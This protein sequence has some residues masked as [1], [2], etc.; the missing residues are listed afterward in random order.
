MADDREPTGE[1]LLYQTEDGRTR[2]ECRFAEETLWLSQALIAELF[3]TTP[4]NV[5]QHLRAIY[6]EGEL[7]PEAT[8]KD[9]LQ[10]RQEGGRR[11]RR[12]VR[13]YNLDAILAVGYRVRSPRGTQFRIWATE[14]LREYL[15]KG[16]SMDD[17][18][19]RN[20]PVEGSGVP[21]YFDELLER[22]RDIRASERRMY[23]RVREIFALAADCDPK[24]ADV[25]EFFQTI[26]NK[27]HYSATGLT[28]AELIV[29]RADHDRPNMG[30]TSWKGAVVRKGDVTVAKNYLSQEEIGELNRIVTMW[31][32]FAEDQARRR[33]QVF[34]RDW[35]TRLDDF[36]RFN[37]RDVLPDKGRISKADADARA[38]AE[39]ERFAERRRALLEAE[40]ALAQERA[41]E[42]AARALHP[43]KGTAETRRP[44]K[45]R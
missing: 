3:Q 36:L 29:A 17:E 14:R 15:V 18:R 33:R 16:F 32:D 4:Q 44:R 41:L 7:Q 22:I 27:L 9:F 13:H 43:A 6:G 38:E 31:L 12:T 1:V 10:V 39:Y 42:E 25:L 24:R 30:L 21:D 40:G 23:L 19:L 2:L 11:V 20:P 35:Q 45:K 34:L 28:A 37:E 8:C 5:T 26:Q